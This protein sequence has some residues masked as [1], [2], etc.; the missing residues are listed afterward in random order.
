MK[1]ERVYDKED[2]LSSEDIQ[3][4]VLYWLSEVNCLITESRDDKVKT[5]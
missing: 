2:E 4:A 5:Q 3:E 1:A